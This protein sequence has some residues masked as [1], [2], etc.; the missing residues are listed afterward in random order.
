[1]EHKLNPF[2]CLHESV[3]KR[4]SYQSDVLPILCVVLISSTVH[5]STRE[6]I[7]AIPPV[8]KLFCKLY[9]VHGYFQLALDK[10]SSRLT[11]F[12]IQQGRF[13]Y[14]R[15]AMGLNASSDEW[16]RQSNV[17]IRGLPFSMKIVDDTIIWAKDEAELEE[18]I[19]TVLSRCEEN[20][21]TISR[22]KMELGNS[23]HFAVHP[24]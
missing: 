4:I 14:L 22:K 9:A 19:E 20:N 18:R 21:I 23:I 1:M 24:P 17:I 12:L 13:R 2:S 7:E 8:A 16:S 10:K 3:N 6:I 11:T 15:K 5:P